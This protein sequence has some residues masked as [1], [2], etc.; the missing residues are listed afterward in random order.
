MVAAVRPDHV[1]DVTVALEGSGETVFAIG[2]VAHGARGCT[3]YGTAGTWS[4]RDN[5][6]AS[7][8]G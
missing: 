3:V 7:H 1:A 8:H 5:W 6:S 2:E 4:A